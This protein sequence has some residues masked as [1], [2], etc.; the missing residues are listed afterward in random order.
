MHATQPPDPNAVSRSIEAGALG[1]GIDAG[2]TYTD[3]VIYDLAKR[4]LVAKAKALTTYHDLSEGVRSVLRLL[5]SHYVTDARIC[6]LSTTLATNAV[7]ERRG[8]S[9]GLIVLAPW[10]W[11]A[12]DIGHTPT[13]RARGAVNASGDIIEPLDE[14]ACRSA[15]LTLTMD[16]Q[17]EAIA[18]AGYGLVRNPEMANRARDIVR[19]VT[20]AP[21]V[22]AH[23]VTRRLNGVQ[24]ART[25]VANARLLPVIDSLLR[26]VSCALAEEGFRGRLMVVRGDGTPMSERV[27]RERPIETLLSGPAASVSGARVLTGLAN[28]MVMDIGGTTTDCAILTDGHVNVAASG[29]QVGGHVMSVDVADICTTG[30]GGDSRIDFDRDRALRIGPQRNVPLCSLAAAH[31]HIRAFVAAFEWRHTR[32]ATDASALDVL[33]LGSPLSRT[34]TTQEQAILDALRDGPVPMLELARRL[35]SPHYRLLPTERLEQAGAIKRGG[36]TPTDILHATGD[37]SRWDAA[38]ASAAMRVFAAMYGSE[39]D[40]L[41]RLIRRLITRRLFDEALRREAITCGMTRAHLPPEWSP[42]LDRAFGNASGALRVGITMDRPIVAIGAP[43]G[44]LAPAISDHMGVQVI[45][46]PDADVANAVGAI[47]GDVVVREEAIICADAIA[48]FLVHLT[49]RRIRARDLETATA[50]ARSLTAERAL[51]RSRESGAVDPRVLVCDIDRTAPSAEGDAV[52]LER[53]VRATASGPA[54]AHAGRAAEQ[55]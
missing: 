55:G 2:G 42:L 46:P 9:V 12:D 26:S 30:L 21:I 29:A 37:F 43:A 4:T 49:D 13:F 3:A 16:H 28:A 47:A 31:P 15:A 25:A 51:A 8:G 11:F 32:A 5:P 40:E 54:F 33:M 45:V 39:A 14:A 7:V 24:A 10:D 41:M 18:I 19:G 23:E 34:W 27:A 38:T 35:R 48:G 22:C 50:T 6:S 1:L 52:F 20:A 36:L 53:T 17:V 44:L